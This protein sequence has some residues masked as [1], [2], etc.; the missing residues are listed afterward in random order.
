M[1]KLGRKR[2]RPPS[3]KTSKYVKYL[4]KALNKELSVIEFDECR[5]AYSCMQSLS[6]T[7]LRNGLSLAMEI[8]SNDVYIYHNS[9]NLVF[10][11]KLIE[12]IV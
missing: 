2:G 9:F 11:P 3:W 12:K 4:E 6:G 5:P 10:E 1:Y 7:I 8:I